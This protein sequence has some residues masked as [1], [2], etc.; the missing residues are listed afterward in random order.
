M[1]SMYVPTNL[2][3]GLVAGTETADTGYSNA[4]LTD[5]VLAKAWRSSAAASTFL[6]YFDRTSATPTP[7]TWVG[8]FDLSCVTTTESIK[9]VVVDD[10]PDNI[11]MTERARFTLNSRGDGGRFAYCPQRYIRLSI[12]TTG[13]TKI[14]CG[15]IVGGYAVMLPK[16]FTRRQQS[17]D[18]GV[19]LNETEGGGVYTGRLRSYRHMINLDWSALDEYQHNAL[20]AAEEAA[21][22]SYTPIVLVPDTNKPA[23]LY[24]GRIEEQT[25]TQNPGALYE[26]HA[27]AFKES[28]RAL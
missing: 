15:L 26:G 4:S 17:R 27:L 5:D 14:D 25:W 11:A 12:V 13:S 6:P 2:L 7:I 20:V 19:V 1:P 18:R 8:V 16:Q 28:G 24:H 10:S 22:G 23:E 9:Y 3:S 21:G